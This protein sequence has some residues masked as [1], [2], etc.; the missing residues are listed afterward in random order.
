[1]MAI[2]MHGNRM[3]ASL[4]EQKTSFTTATATAAAAAAVDMAGWHH[5]LGHDAAA[6]SVAG[7]CCPGCC[8]CL[9]DLFLLVAVLLSPFLSSLQPPTLASSSCVA[10]PTVRCICCMSAVLLAAHCAAV[11]RQVVARGG[12]EEGRNAS[13]CNIWAFCGDHDK[14]KERFGECWLKRENKLPPPPAMPPGAK[15]SEGWISGAVYDNHTHL[16]QYNTTGLVFHT[17]LGDIEMELLPELAPASVRELRRMAALLQPIG[18]YCSNCR[19]YRPEKGFLVQGAL[20][21]PGAYVATP[22][23]PN[24]Q[25]K[26][27]MEKGLVCWA[28][29]GGG[30]HFFVNM[31]D[32]SG[33]K[34]DHLCFA[35]TADA[36]MAVYDKILELPLKEKQKP[37]DMNSLKEPM[38]FNVTLKLVNSGAAQQPATAQ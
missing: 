29:G 9:L 3:H 36:S 21:A 32:Q 11:H 24:P 1:M 18:G 5:R 27:V 22:R 20:E 8:C 12:T 38:Y 13:S 25:Q 10:Q 19:I 28:G 30:P 34:D 2:W 17:S 35:K 26:M 15:K 14:C 37:N 16:E 6:T 23:R 7:W 33:F 31:I 4:V